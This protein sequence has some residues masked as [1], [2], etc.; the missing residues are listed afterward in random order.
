MNKMTSEDFY[1]YGI[2]HAAK[3]YLNGGLGIS[4]VYIC[5]ASFYEVL[6]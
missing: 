5:Y 6:V 1:V 2:A 4:H 3:H